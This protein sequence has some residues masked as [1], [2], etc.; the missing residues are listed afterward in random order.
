MNKAMKRYTF[1]CAGIILL[2]LAAP[3]YA[4]AVRLEYS[5]SQDG[6]NF[7]YH[8][9]FLGFG[10]VNLTDPTDPPQDIRIRFLFMKLATLQLSIASINPDAVPPSLTV[11][12]DLTP[13]RLLSRFIPNTLS[14]DIPALFGNAGIRIKFFSK[15]FFSSTGNDTDMRLLLTTRRSK[16]AID[17][18]LPQ[19][20]GNWE[21]EA[22]RQD[23][24]IQQEIIYNNIKFADINLTFTYMPVLFTKVAYSIKVTTNPMNPSDNGS[25]FD[26]NLVLPNGSYYVWYNVAP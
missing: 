20:T 3:R 8:I 18:N 17:Y 4:E 13:G 26:G 2:L 1:A 6:F 15:W 10:R 24:Q 21:G 22:N 19:L 7:K 5:A 11:H 9:P 14:G 12:Y 23:N 25:S 16:Y